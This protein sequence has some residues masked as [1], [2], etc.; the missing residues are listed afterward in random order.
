MNSKPRSEA[1][2]E[3]VEGYE[4]Q[5]R[6]LWQWEK[7][8]LSGFAMFRRLQERRG[9]IVVADLISHSLK[10]VPFAAAPTR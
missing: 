4:V 2:H 1:V 8:I 6:P 10:F 9:G 5:V 3:F 7:A